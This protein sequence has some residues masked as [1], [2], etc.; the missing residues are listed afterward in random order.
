M[1]LYTI[2]RRDG[3]KNAD[4]LE[5]AA[6]T[7]LRIGDDEMSKD[8]RWIRTYV[9][10]ESDGSLGTLCIYQQRSKG[11]YR[12]GMIGLDNRSGYAPVSHG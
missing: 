6:A 3:W 1:Q 8:I 10:K 2:C 7:S 9:L 11:G 4:Q 12:G 5:A